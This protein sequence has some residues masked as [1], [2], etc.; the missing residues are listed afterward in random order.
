ME[1]GIPS[2]FELFAL[3]TAL[4]VG[5]ALVLLSFVIF[6]I[7]V[8]PLSEGP[9]RGART[10]VGLSVFVLAYFQLTQSS[11]LASIF[12][13]IALAYLLMFPLGVTLLGYKQL[14]TVDSSDTEDG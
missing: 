13:A 14:T 10:L 5:I 11:R 4:T 12:S 7:G 9:S 1:P 2:P 6:F 8:S 3:E